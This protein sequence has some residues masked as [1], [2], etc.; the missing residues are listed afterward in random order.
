MDTEQAPPGNAESNTKDDSKEAKL[1]QITG[2]K[3][4][5]L[6]SSLALASLLLMLDTSVV[7]TVCY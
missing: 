5:I 6:L 7:S 4:V 1:D 2:I 3:L